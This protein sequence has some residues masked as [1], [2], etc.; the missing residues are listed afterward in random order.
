MHVAHTLFLRNNVG[1]RSQSQSAASGK[2]KLRPRGGGLFL[3]R[4]IDVTVVISEEHYLYKSS[5][6]QHNLDVQGHCT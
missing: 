4:L 3:L 2:D 5:I 1:D 6:D